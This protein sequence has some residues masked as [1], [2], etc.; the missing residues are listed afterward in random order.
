MY[1]LFFYVFYIFVTDTPKNTIFFIDI[2]DNL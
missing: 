2:A 1:S